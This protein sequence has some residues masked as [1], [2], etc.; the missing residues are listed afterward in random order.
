MGDLHP[1]VVM[2]TVATSDGGIDILTDDSIVSISGDVTGDV[3]RVLGLCDGQRSVGDI[4]DA[5][6][7]YMSADMAS[8]IIDDLVTIGVLE[9]SRRVYRRFHKLTSNPSCYYYD[10]SR[11]DLHNWL[12]NPLRTIH[13]IGD[14]YT[15]RAGKCDSVIV[16]LQR[17]RHSVRSYT[18]DPLNGWQ[19]MHLCSTGYSLRNH[20]VPSGG[21][22]YPLRLFVAVR[23]E[24]PSLPSGYYEYDHNLNAL[25]RFSDYD[26]QAINYICG[27]SRS[28]FNAPVLIVIAADFNRQA[29]KYANKAYR[30]ALIEAGQ[31][32]QNITLAAVEM[33]LGTCELGG[34]LDEACAEEFGMTEDCA[35]VLGMTVGYESQVNWIDDADAYNVVRSEIVD[36]L[37]IASQVSQYAYDGSRLFVASAQIKGDGRNYAGGVSLSGDNAKLKAVVEA[38]ERYVSE[39]PRMDVV[40]GAADLDCNWVDPRHI[41]PLAPKQII[42]MHLDEFD[43]QLVISWTR[44]RTCSGD[45]VMV[46]TDL[47][48]YGRNLG[49]VR[50]LYGNSSGVA[51]YG[52]YD[53]AVRRACFELI[54]RDAL[55]RMWYLRITPAKLE[56]RCLDLYTRRR[57]EY[58]KQ[59]GITVEFL[60]PDSQIV[61]AIVAIA[62]G[63]KPPYFAS[64]AA[65]G[66]SAGE[67]VLKALNELEY[68][69]YASL[70]ETVEPIS[71]EQVETPSDH[72]RYY[73]RSN[74]NDILSFMWQGCAVDHCDDVNIST[75][76]LLRQMDAIVVDMSRP[77]LTGLIKVVRVLSPKMIPISF[78][79]GCGHCT[80]PS[81]GLDA[82]AD[83]EPHF[84]A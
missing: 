53:G 15:V 72:G 27:T 6:R 79:Y 28:L 4:V 67:C 58:W 36:R 38:Y 17:K 74:H 68:S 29:Y 40:S 55:M 2:P 81:L 69:L 12:Q 35:P 82:S 83:D 7:D 47:V 50:I 52:D 39:N 25:G 42:D 24:C 18:D 62:R 41:A 51:A 20:A 71:K 33:G 21:G 57:I 23:R 65:A 8:K 16:D 14:D 31:V 70:D 48:Y 3:W 44:G 30:L 63:N 11:E 59:R 66:T 19:V 73:S 46:P 80:H 37:G 45:T 9:D 76:E 43:D 13:K 22:L 32:A 78:G 84:F 56:P 77:D 5:V 49:D 54:E 10:R 75:D 61:P 26:E 1:I 60:M 34:L 64:G